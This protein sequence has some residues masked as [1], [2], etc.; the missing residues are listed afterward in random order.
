MS[1]PITIP[2]PAE[3]AQ[4]IRDLRAELAALMK[5]HRLAKAAAAA[6]E[7]RARRQG[8]PAPVAV[9]NKAG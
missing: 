7:A 5:L 8:G 6:D 2:P 4:R 9:G 3:I 1:E